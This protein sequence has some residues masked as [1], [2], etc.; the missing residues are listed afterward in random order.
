MPFGEINHAADH[1]HGL[2]TCVTA[3]ETAVQDMSV[4]A[5]S[6]A[7]AVFDRPMLTATG[8]SVPQGRQDS[9]RII[10]MNALFPTVNGLQIGRAPSEHVFDIFGPPNSSA[11]DV[12]IP[13]DIPCRL[14]DEP[15]ALVVLAKSVFR[16]LRLQ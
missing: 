5:V 1:P 7:K 3:H 2:A 13:N 4:R 16:A 9:L 12:P 14:A 11:F 10:G 15:K 8:D 6:P